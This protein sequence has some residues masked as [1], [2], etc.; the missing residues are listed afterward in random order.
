MP[1]HRFSFLALAYPVTPSGVTGE[2][3]LSCL[4]EHQ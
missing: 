3:S 1:T 2:M 4:P